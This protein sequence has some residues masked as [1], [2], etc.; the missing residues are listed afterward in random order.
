MTTLKYP[1]ICFDL[2]GTLVDD[3]IYIWKTLHERFNTDKKQ[4]LQAYNDYFNKIISYQDWF[5]TDLELLRS[6]GASKKLILET[7]NSLTVMKGALETL[8]TLQNSGHK[9]AIISGSL[10]IVV[11]HL[12]PDFKF[13]HLLINKITFDQNG[14]I[15]GGTHTPYDI[16][17]KADG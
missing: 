6:A 1:L 12:F 8:K 16:E 2:D 3:T 11:S 7:L 13:D 9:I 15:Q 4:R 10:D 14:L 5:D 17:A